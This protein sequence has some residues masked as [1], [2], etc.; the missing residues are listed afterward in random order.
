MPRRSSTP[1]TPSKE[2]NVLGPICRMPTSSEEGQK[3]PTY[4]HDMTWRIFRIM[5]EFVEGFEFLSSLKREVT[6][7]GSARLPSGSEWYEEARVLGELLAACGYTVVTGGGPGIMEAANRGAH[8]AGG[9]SVGLNIQLPNE[10]RINPYVGKARAFHYFFTRKVMLMASAQAYVVFPGGYGTLDELFELI[11]LIQTKK[12]EHV[13]VIL[14]GKVFWTPL[15]HWLR[16]T[17]QQEYKVIAKVDLELFELVD[18]AEE[19][20]HLVQHS[21]DRHL[22]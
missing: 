4:L 9:V 7:F 19:A 1:T 15:V 12:A 11:T 14:V 3:K 2:P 16:T 22:F 5:S 8:E 17:L 20:F 21:P 18:T 13:P 10:Q 6:V